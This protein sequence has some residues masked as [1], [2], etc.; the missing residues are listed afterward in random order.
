MRSVL[1]LAFAAILSAA[2]A[3]TP[4][5]DAVV[6]GWQTNTVY[7]DASMRSLV[8]EADAER[9]RARTEGHEPK[10][11]IAVVPAAA[12]TDQTGG[13]REAA[14]RA[15]VDQAVDARRQDGIY[16]VVFG[17]AVVWGSAV[18]VDAPVG[19]IL[20]D[21]L[22]KHT[23]SEPV[24]LLDGVLTRLGVPDAPGPE[25]T[26][27]YRLIIGAGIA[28][29]IGV[30]LLVWW[31]VRRRKDE[32]PALYRPSFE[33]LPDEADSVDDRRKLALEDV[34]RFGEELD[35][36]DVSV[37]TDSVAAHVQAAMDA[38]QDA[39]RI[40]D[41]EPDDAALRTMRATVEYGRWRLAV[42]KATLAGTPAPPRR[43]DCFFDPAHGMSTTDW[44]Y[45]P[46]GGRPREI[47]VCAAC[48]KRLSGE[49]R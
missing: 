12:L 19:E 47:P 42:A 9:L 11:L 7:V 14:A 37:E 46:A 48:A 32:G 44:M 31:R 3:S 49:I 15:F 5:V 2:P 25:R 29:A 17:G 36:S 21:E 45:T 38:Y 16:L 1:G 18:G 34:T 39:G 24:A 6:D 20:T 8:P 26:I 28:L 41:S 43:V 33:V 35:A 27:P 30:G 40:A 23:R 22:T 4:A 10:V 13:T